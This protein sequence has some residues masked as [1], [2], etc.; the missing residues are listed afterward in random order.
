MRGSVVVLTILANSKHSK[1]PTGSS[2]PG[3]QSPGLSCGRTL[4]FQLMRI[5]RTAQERSRNIKA[6]RK[7]G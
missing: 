4:F 6:I 3:T 2:I 7:M 1:G 5:N